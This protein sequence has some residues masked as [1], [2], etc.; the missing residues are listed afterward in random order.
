MLQ[1][2]ALWYVLESDPV[3]HENV[4]SLFSILYYFAADSEL[5]SRVC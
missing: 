5:R 4:C 3:S 1:A 2:S